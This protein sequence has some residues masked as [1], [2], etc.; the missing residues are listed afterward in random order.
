MNPAIQIGMP[1]GAAAVAALG[2][3]T[4]WPSAQLWGPA[5]WR[6]P[7][8][9]NRVAITFDDGPTSG[10]TERVLDE[11]QKHRVPATFFAIGQNVENAPEVLRRI[12]AE[13][14]LV[15][16]HTFSHSHYG[17]LRGSRFW[18]CELTQ[19]DDAIESIL[20]KRPT[21][22][23]PPLGAKS[24]FVVGAAQ[25]RQLQLVTW[26]LRAIDG[27][28]TTTDRIM[29]RFANVRGGDILVLHD[30]ADP[31]VPHRDRSTAANV[32]EPLVKLL[33]ER[34]LEPVRLDSLLSATNQPAQ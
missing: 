7:R 21:F 23:R 18:E 2:Y 19:T 13:G 16:N 25:R 27:V 9:S 26:S 31:R 8:N 10:S 17:V 22:F 20:H 24:C 33:R 32:I 34:N 15:G 6:G 14:H 12:D 3:A 29:R 28:P 1:L 11:L 5:V 4:V 30:G